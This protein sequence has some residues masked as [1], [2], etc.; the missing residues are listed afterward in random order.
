MQL[1]RA[2]VF[3]LL[4]AL[5]AVAAVSAVGTG[6]KQD[7]PELRLVAGREV[8]L[9]R[10]SAY[11][12]AGVAN[13]ALLRRLIAGV[14]PAVGEVRRGRA[15]M[16]VRYD[17]G[18]VVS[19]ALSLTRG[20]TVR[21][22]GQ[23]FSSAIRA[24]AVQQAQRNTCESAALEILVATTGRRIDQRR[25]Q[26]AFPVSGPLDPQG[27][28]SDWIWGDPDEGYVGRPDGGG[29]AGGFGIYPGPVRATAARFGVRLDD[30]SGASPDSVYR[31]LLGGRAV[32]AWV[33]LS[34]GPFEEWRSPSGDPVR[35]NLGEHTIVLNGIRADG[36]LLVSNPLEG[37]REVWSRSQFEAQ[38]ESLGR[39]A[40]S[41]A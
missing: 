12:R 14:V 9:I 30:L 11:R 19:R 21:A 28:E 40:L 22:P 26:R 8:T 38:W 17:R 36:S 6:G 5:S 35:V 31:R 1:R 34:D 32:M 3:L 7:S 37:T 33:G 25:I 23:A 24:P 18:A 16:R 2:S 39:R 29:V 15:T 20:G 10:V 41:P 4:L 13:V 27:S